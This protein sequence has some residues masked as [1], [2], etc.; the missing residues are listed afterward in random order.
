MLC[1]F[2]DGAGIDNNF[3]SALPGLSRSV[4]SGPVIPLNPLRIRFICL[5]PERFNK[6]SLLR[7]IRPISHIC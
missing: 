7:P 1:P 2:A 6:I 3:I 5:T 4:P